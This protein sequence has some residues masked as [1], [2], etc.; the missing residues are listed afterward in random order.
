M[1]IRDRLF[2]GV[3][4]VDPV[5]NF[6]DNCFCCTGESEKATRKE[7][8]NVIES[9]G[10]RFSK[11]ITQNINYLVVGAAGNRAWAFSCYGRK[12][13]EVMNLRRKGIKIQLIHEFDFW[14]AVEDSKIK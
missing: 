10:G 14:D 4:A 9:L 5:I 7:I 2:D 8:V 12:V 3:C 1:C 6:E 13:E 11:N